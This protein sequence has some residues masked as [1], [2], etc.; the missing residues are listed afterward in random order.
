MHQTWRLTYVG[1]KNKPKTS[2]MILQLFHG[3]IKKKI[4]LVSMIYVVDL[5]GCELHPEDEIVFNNF[6][7]ICS[8]MGSALKVKTRNHVSAF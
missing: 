3:R 7:D 8:G 1:I 4:V 5:D 2:D 6:M